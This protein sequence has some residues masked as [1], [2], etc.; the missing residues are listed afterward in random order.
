MPF[1]VLYAL[2]PMKRKYN[3]I[4]LT[5]AVLKDQYVDIADAEKH[6]VI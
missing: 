3:L 1:V 6:L 5:V 2:I 4:I